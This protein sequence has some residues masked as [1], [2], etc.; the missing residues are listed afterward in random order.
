MKV[1]Q[2]N[3]IRM[4]YNTVQS[5]H[6]LGLSPFDIEKKI[7]SEWS[8]PKYRVVLVNGR[9]K[10]KNFETNNIELLKGETFSDITKCNP[11]KLTI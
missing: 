6:N 1:I 7:N 9:I 2:I 3:S 11:L 5:L 10:L 8:H 4:L